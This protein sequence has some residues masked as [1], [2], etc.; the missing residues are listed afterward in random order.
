MKR[1]TLLT[2]E[3]FVEQPLALLGSAKLDKNK[4]TPAKL[5]A[6][7]QT[8]QSLINSITNSLILGEIPLRPRLNIFTPQNTLSRNKLARRCHTLM[9]GDNAFSHTHSP[10]WKVS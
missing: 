2:T 5:G 6:A 9:D 10:L 4:Q 7:L 1:I 3:V 8:L